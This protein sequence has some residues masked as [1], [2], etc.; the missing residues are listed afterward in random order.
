MKL[1]MES[2][3]GAS[4]MMGEQLEFQYGDDLIEEVSN[5]EEWL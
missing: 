1:S 5:V 2:V 3:V 4:K